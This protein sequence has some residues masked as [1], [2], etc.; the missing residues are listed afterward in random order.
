MSSLDRDQSTFDGGGG[1]DGP[2]VEATGRIAEATQGGTPSEPLKDMAVLI[3]EDEAIINLDLAMTA[4]SFG[5]RMVV[6]AHNLEEARTAMKVGQFDIAVLD[7]SLPDGDSMPLAEELHREGV[8]LFFHSGDEG[9]T[10]V[11][12]G[13]PGAGFVMKPAT[14]KSWSGVFAEMAN[15]DG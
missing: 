11:L 13:F 7:L 3:V 10:D 12:E 8:R 2:A 6:S 4:E 9:R 15:A 5:A 14:E 1:S